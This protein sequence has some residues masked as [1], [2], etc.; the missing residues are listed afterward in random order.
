MADLD[1]AGKHGTSGSVDLGV[2]QK[3]KEEDQEAD[4]DALVE[5]GPVDKKEDPAKT[6]ELKQAAEMGIIEKKYAPKPSEDAETD[7][8][9]DPSE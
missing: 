4:D 2:P 9:D 7:N 8:E 6:S 5:Q 3:S 1:E